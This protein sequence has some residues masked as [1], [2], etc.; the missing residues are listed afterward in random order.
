MLGSLSDDEVLAAIESIGTPTFVVA[1]G[2][3]GLFRYLGVNS[4]NTRFSG[5]RTEDIR[6]R[7]PAEV[8]PAELAERLEG[9][10][11]RCLEAAAP[12]Q[13]EQRLNFPSG[14]RWMFTALAPLRAAD[15]RIRRILGN[16]FDVTERRRIESELAETK[17][18]L[19]NV[20]D[21]IPAI[22]FCKDVPELR[23][24]L[25]NRAARALFPTEAVLGK[26]D[27]DV[28]PPELAERFRANDRAA[29]ARAAPLLIEDAPMR[30]IDGDRILRMQKLPIRDRDGRARH[31]LGVAEDVTERVTAERRLRDAVESLR[32]GFMLFDRDDRVVLHNRRFLEVY[33]YLAPLAPLEG[34]TFEDMLEASE[35]W[36]RGTAPAAEVDAYVAARR[37][38]WRSFS[39]TPIEMPLP[40]GGWVMVSERPTA[41]GGVVAIH[42]DITAQKQA[43]ARLVEAI[44][45]IDQGFILFDENDRLVL[46]NSKLLE[47]FPGAG[48]AMRLGAGIREIIRA[49]AAS[50]DYRWDYATLDQAVEEIHRIYVTG[51]TEGIER[52]LRDG[53]WILF[54]QHVTPSGF[55]VGL[56]TD[57]TQLKQRQAQLS[58]I[59]DRLHQQ[60]A[61]LIRL[62]EDLREARRRAEQANSAKS[63][64][65]AMISHELRT[66]FTGIRGMADLLAAT[67]L[68]AEQGRYLDVMRR[69]IDRL[70]ALLDQILDF[71][72]I[73]AGRLEVEETAMSPLQVA[74]DAATIFRP[75]ALAKGLALA[76]EVGTDVPGR[77]L[78]DPQKTNQILANLIGNAIKFTERGAV[79]IG[80]S[81]VRGGGGDLLRW[82]VADTGIGLAEEQIGRLFEP[83]S[84]ADNSTTRRFGGTGLGLAISKRLAAAMGGEMGVDSAVARGS[85][86][87]FTTRF[88]LATPAS[89]PADDPRGREW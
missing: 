39:E 72:R 61:D 40:T 44:E 75:T 26:D 60:T 10:Y 35:A 25:I 7:R 79:T 23:Y 29:I 88:R 2:N 82:R 28:H 49:G 71:S 45:S 12:V 84:Q 42:T 36:R 73:E 34:R 63:Q 55:R 30:T 14:P 19:Q 59:G 32:D 68:S 38:H 53:R 65:L 27:F 66:P 17:D 89:T 58:E 15:G 4:A 1:V 76:V 22:V 21:H 67:P 87:W 37:R 62:T 31:V 48:A 80:V 3:D 85:A 20:I 18:F 78:G 6:G 64:F 69:S 50:G 11:R 16:S 43:E 77:V 81:V 83:F 57:I 8:M 51:T 56:R 24:T 74:E 54:S 52:Q 13:Y 86:F 33:P 47:M 46:W 70:L 41:D 9:E 5:R